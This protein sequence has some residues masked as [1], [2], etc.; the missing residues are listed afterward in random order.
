MN[1]SLQDKTNIDYMVRKYG[2]R[3]SREF[4]GK[5]HSNSALKKF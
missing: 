1:R 3:L 2:N 4:K 5:P